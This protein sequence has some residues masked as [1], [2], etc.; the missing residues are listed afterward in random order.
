MTK[1]ARIRKANIKCIE[2]IKKQIKEKAA[3]NQVR[4]L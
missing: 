3:D 4:R 2:F 1:G